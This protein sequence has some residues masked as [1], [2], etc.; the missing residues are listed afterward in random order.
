[1]SISFSVFNPITSIVENNISNQKIFAGLALTNNALIPTTNPMLKFISL[2]AVGTYF[3]LSS[4]EYARARKY[5]AAYS[6]AETTPAYIYFGKFISAAIA[7]YIRG[8]KISSPATQ[9]ALLQLT[10]AG[11]LNVVINGVNYNTTGIDLTTA[12]SMSDVASIITTDIQTA[13]VTLTNFTITYDGVRNTFFAKNDV[14]GSAETMNYFSSATGGLVFG[15]LFAQVQGAILS[16]G[17]DAQTVPENLQRLKPLFLDQF[18]IMF[19]DEMDG[20]VTDAENVALAQWVSDQDS[21]YNSLVWANQGPIESETDTSSV[22]YLINQ[23]GIEN[24]SIFDELNL[25]NSD[26]VFA[27]SGIIASLDLTQ[28]NSAITPAFKTQDGLEPS[29]SDTDIAIILN[30]KKINYYGNVGISGSPTVLNFF[31]GG[32]TTGKWGYTDNLVGQVWIAYQCNV[33]IARLF[34]SIGQVVNDPDGAGLVRAA[35]TDAVETAVFNGIIAKGVN[36]DT[37]TQ[38]YIKT[39]YGINPVDLTNN[40][41]VIINSPSTPSQRQNR[42]SSVWSILYVKGSAIQFLPIRTDTFF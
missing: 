18:T 26:R 38:L 15:L 35:L 28:L 3:G 41:Y 13:H 25:D 39:R 31:Y 5:F 23:A 9:L 2:D 33:S 36:F 30:D 10:S 42:I 19:T 11:V 40:G 17:A 20:F 12:T 34:T 22:W 21:K 4:V 37:A 29:V 7:P 14:T 16:Q 32:Y 6:T 8:A 27:Y 24:C 1:M